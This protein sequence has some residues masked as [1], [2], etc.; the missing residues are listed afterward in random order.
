MKS[1]PQGLKPIALRT[2]KVAAKAPDCAEERKPTERS[3]HDQEELSSRS[4]QIGLALRSGLLFAEHT[5][6]D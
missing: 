2:V 5:G 1:V 6:G 3:T 4:G